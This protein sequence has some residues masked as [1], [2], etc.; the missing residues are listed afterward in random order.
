M[1]N[2]PISDGTL[3]QQVLSGD[4]KSLE[5]LV[6]RYWIGIFKILRKT[7]RPQEQA[8]D[9]CQEAFLHAVKKLDQFDTSRS[10]GPWVARIALNVAKE[11]ARRKRVVLMPL[12]FS[13]DK[14]SVNQVPQDEKLSSRCEIDGFLEL[15][16]IE[17][18][19]IFLM[20]HALQLK[21]EEIAE[22]LETPVSTIKVYLF[23]SRSILRQK[24]FSEKG[25]S[26]DISD[27]RVT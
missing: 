20:K 17:L 13:A 5:E 12:S 1:T 10:F 8:E 2:F 24:V 14:S 22:L 6:S 18:R 3:V 16:P 9:I 15:L 4:R 25:I 19:I 26:E 7:V 27:D 21:I 23:R 11:H